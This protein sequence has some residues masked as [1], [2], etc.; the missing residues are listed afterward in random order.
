M[1]DFP[2]SGVELVAEVSQ[3]TRNMQ[4]AL[5]D[6]TRL[7]KQFADVVSEADRMQRALNGIDGDVDVRVNLAG[8]DLTRLDRLN[9]VDV[10]IRTDITD[11]TALTRIENV[12]DQ[13]VDFRTDIADDTAINRIEG[14]A[15]QDVDFKTNISDDTAIRRIEN[16]ED[17][18]V[19]LK[20]GRDEV[21]AKLE[22]VKTQLNTIRNLATISL[23]IKGAELL[24]N[25]QS[26]P[27]VST[28]LEMDSAV[29]TVN[30]R[31]LNEIPNA[32]AVVNDLYTDAWGESRAQIADVIVEMSRLG[33]ANEDL[34]AA[35]EDVFQVATATGQ[36][37]VEILRRMDTLVKNGLV[38]NFSAAGDVIVGAFNSGLNRADDFLETVDEY[39]QVVNDTGLSF[40]ALFEIQ[41]AGLN[42]GV[43]DTDKLVDSYKE[44]LN[45]TR[46]EA[47]RNISFGEETDRTVALEELGL[48]DEAAA[49]TQGELVADQFV[50][51]VLDNLRAVED[52]AK[53]RELA[54]AIFNPSMVE[55]AGLPGLLAADLSEST[56]V[57]A[58]FEGIA[59]ESAGILKDNLT[60]AY[61]EAARTLE[62][63]LVTA[64]N[65]AID[66]SGF[67]ENLKNA[68]V[69]FSDTLEGGGS[70]GEGITVAL[71]LPDETFQKFE[72]VFNN[73]LLGLG[74]IVAN[75]FSFLGQGE[76]AAGI[77]ASIEDAAVGQLQFDLQVADDAAGV[78]N[79]IKAAIRRG[80]DEADISASLQGAAEEMLSSGDIVGA[81]DLVSSALAL[82]D[83]PITIAGVE[84]PAN[85]TRQEIID[86]FQSQ[87]IGIPIPL[88]E[89]DATF[90]ARDIDTTQIEEQIAAAGAEVGTRVGELLSSGDVAS[91]AEA[92]VASGDVALLTTAFD[93][94][95]A[96]EMPEVAQS[97]KDEMSKLVDGTDQY[98]QPEIDR[99]NAALEQRFQTALQFHDLDLALD[100]A[101]RI[102]LGDD[103]SA[104][105]DQLRT[106][107]D[108]AI[109]EG[110]FQFADQIAEQLNNPALQQQVDDLFAEAQEAKQ[111]FLEMQ[112]GSK[113]ATD[114]MGNVSTE[115]ARI[116]QTSG[117]I[118]PEAAKQVTDYSDS[119]QE[120]ID[121]LY[122]RMARFTAE[123]RTETDAV[124]T[125][126]KGAEPYWERYRT[127]AVEQIDLIGERIDYVREQ[128]QGLTNDLAVGS[129]ADVPVPVPVGDVPEAAGGGRF[130][131]GEIVKVGERG[132]ELITMPREGAIVNAANTSALTQALMGMGM[133]G[134]QTVNNYNV[135][136]TNNVRTQSAAQ[137]GF[138]SQGFAR[139]LRGFL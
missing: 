57:V 102:D 24:T 104:I 49:Y 116:G 17:A 110:D 54:L 6:A 118:M 138:Y 9:D 71:G 81:R 29:A 72:S 98:M 124:G 47:S 97:I 26:L 91:A 135:V 53:Q 31:T 15:D 114:S 73:L 75:V 93:A 41:R 130:G 101:S 34:A 109:A 61:T 8:D 123:N 100:V 137:A 65:N 117:L 89:I 122:V 105:A 131:A 39:S 133:G 38:P 92:A 48:F 60:T 7:D 58:A 33:I 52:P 99:L 125:T 134:G 18:T 86:H 36:D 87:L 30:A 108:T 132:A 44:F 67:L 63:E 95:L 14:V 70:I 43:R 88:D 78:Q 139:Q 20:V 27:V 16:V 76:A 129:G 51:A 113:A 103:Q 136:L 37:P 111:S 85:T 128:T 107:F 74:E 84:F 82:Q 94:A 62:T 40:D 119:A 127:Y 77:R 4:R 83:V 5:Q 90:A 23:V 121:L 96:A 69:T 19:D 68:A 42:E 35:G 11:D 106:L 25:I 10:S 32:A 2:Q 64:L 50:A 112:E 3:Y 21:T 28:I 46:E 13:D 126:L 115:V 45:L 1:P 120:D 59:E 55:D 79:A 12:E 66:I 22:G 80:V 56:D